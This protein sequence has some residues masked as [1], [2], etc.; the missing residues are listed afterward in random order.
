MAK[1]KKRKGQA[2]QSNFVLLNRSILDWE[3]WSDMYVTHFFIGLILLANHED[4]SV[5]GIKVKRGQLLTSVSKLESRLLMNHNCILNCIKK[6]KSSGEIIDDVKPNKYR[7][8]TIVNYDKFQGFVD[9]STDNCADNNTGNRTD[10]QTGNTTDNSADTNN[11]YISNDIYKK[12]KKVSVCPLGATDTVKKE[13]PPSAVSPGGEPPT[14]FDYEKI[15][16]R[17]V[18]VFEGEDGRRLV[19]GKG[20]P[21]KS[22]CRF[23]RAN[24]IDDYTAGDFHSAFKLSGAPFPRNWEKIFLGFAKATGK[25]QW[26]FRQRLSNGEYIEQWTD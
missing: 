25:Q 12:D 3:W 24:N 13:T 8:I 5:R 1:A 19:F 4:K 11:K 20:M 21:Y 15:D 26:E 22:V 2:P 23:A 6:L 17:V 9:R 7:I 16:W 14:A 10:N 18:Q